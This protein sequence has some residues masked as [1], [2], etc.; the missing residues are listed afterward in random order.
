MFSGLA[1]IFQFTRVFTFV[2]SCL[3]FPMSFSSEVVSSKLRQA[4]LEQRFGKMNSSAEPSQHMNC[5]VF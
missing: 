3:F 2:V 1:F 4:R 5:F